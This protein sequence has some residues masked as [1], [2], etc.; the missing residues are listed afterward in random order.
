M[1]Y[2][3]ALTNAASYFGEVVEDSFEYYEEYFCSEPQGEYYIIN[4]IAS[5]G[6]RRIAIDTYWN[7]YNIKG[8]K[9]LKVYDN[10]KKGGFNSARYLIDRKGNLYKREDGFG[11][12]Y[13]KV[14]R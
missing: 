9:T 14:E 11:C 12:E 13:K 4:V 7:D 8:I 10:Y 6:R 5:D 1:S 3:T 2:Y